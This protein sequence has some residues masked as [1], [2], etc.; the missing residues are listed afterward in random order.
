ML[1]MLSGKTHEV[2]TALAVR[3]VPDGAEIVDV[4]MTRATF[5]PLSDRDI[6]DYVVTGEP[7]GKAG[8]YGIQG[9]GGKFIKRI[10][11]CYFNVMGLPISR[12][13][14]TLRSMGWQGSHDGK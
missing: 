5:L 6:K 2:F 11:G 4:E 10:E 14:V 9:I 1:R 12:L 7:F 3:R 13:W 8:G